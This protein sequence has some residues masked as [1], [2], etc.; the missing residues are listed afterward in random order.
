MKNHFLSEFNGFNGLFFRKLKSSNKTLG[1]FLCM[2]FLSVLTISSGCKTKKLASDK[3]SKSYVIYPAPPEAT[4]VNVELV[5]AQTDTLIG[6]LMI[7]TF[8]F[9]VAVTAVLEA[10][11]QPLAVAST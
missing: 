4:T 2:S 10:V 1:L 6:W 3:D 8:V 5:P 9:I 11:V 7:D